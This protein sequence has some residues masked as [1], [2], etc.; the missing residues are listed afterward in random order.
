LSIVNLKVFAF[1]TSN[2]MKKKNVRILALILGLIVL[3]LISRNLGKFLLSS[4]PASQSD[5]IFVLLGP[6]PDRALLAADLY[7]TK[8][9]PRILMANEYQA[10]LDA[11][12]A[13]RLHIDKT[14]D[15]FKTAIMS[16]GVPEKDIK[17]L[18]EVSSSTKDEALILKNYLLLHPEINSVIIV[19]SSYHGLRTKKIFKKAI[20]QLDRDI[21]VNIPFNK[22]SVFYSNKWW[23]DR[24]S[25]K[26]VALEYLKIVNYYLSD[27]FSL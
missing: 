23:T 22:H 18:P 6:V 27:Q 9:A 5:L 15:V 24:Y 20:G 16:L 1:Y 11:V 2:P 8:M 4:S 17:L 21:L 26:M 13:E 19:T 12:L 10:G 3:L 25:A 14:A 7:H